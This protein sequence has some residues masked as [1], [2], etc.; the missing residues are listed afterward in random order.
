[1]K[2]AVIG[3]GGIGKGH[4][5]NLSGM[6]EADLVAVADID[7]ER[8]R[9]ICDE[10]EVKNSYTDYDVMMDREDLDAVFVCTPPFAHLGPVRSAADRDIA[11][12]I[13]KPLDSKIKRAKEIVEVCEDSKIVNQ[14]G[15]HWRFDSGR[16]AAREILLKE[17][18]PVGMVEGR[19]WGGVYRVPWWTKRDLSGG[20]ITEQ[21]THIFDQARWLAGEV[22]SLQALMATRMNFDMEDYDIEDV[23]AVLLEFESGAIGL[24]SSTNASVRYEVG[25]KV[26]AKNLKYEDDSRRIKVSWKDREQDFEGEGSPYVAEEKAFLSSV[27]SG[28]PSEVNVS[29]GLRSVELSLGA[30]K[31]SQQRSRVDLP[32]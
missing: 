6:D 27:E 8:S 14:M 17:G 30:I 29:E 26:V 4:V 5:Q 13:E 15:Y 2:V 11:V 24:V 3:V 22:K 10:F 1:M 7:D 31:A 19:W 20:Q 23:S 12:F 18:G 25:V 32:L 9:R 28:E 16:V 21:T